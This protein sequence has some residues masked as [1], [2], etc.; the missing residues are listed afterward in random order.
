MWSQN[1]I[2]KFLIQLSSPP[3]HNLTICDEFNEENVK[4]I[5]NKL[6]GDR[7]R[8]I[9]VKLLNTE[10]QFED[11]N[12]VNKIYKYFLHCKLRFPKKKNRFFFSQNLRLFE[13]FF[14]LTTEIRGLELNSFPMGINCT[15]F[16]HKLSPNLTSL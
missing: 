10:P 13:E 11:P 12:Q 6:E 9:D 1:S 8:F 7:P 5:I 15:A 4:K 2:L 3:T 14:R 16:V